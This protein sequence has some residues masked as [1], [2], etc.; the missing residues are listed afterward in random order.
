MEIVDEIKNLTQ[1]FEPLFKKE[2]IET[3]EKQRSFY[4]I[5]DTTQDE[6]KQ[7]ILDYSYGGKRI[8]P[9][10]VSYFAGKD[11]SD[12]QV[13]NACMAFEFFHLSALIHDDIIDNADFRRNSPTIHSYAMKFSKLS[14]TIGRDLAILYGDLFLTKCF[15]FASNLE[16]R[17][18]ESFFEMAK[19]T[20]QGQY[21]D[22]IGSNEEYGTIPEE[23]I[24]GRHELKTA[25]YTFVSPAEIGTSLKET[26]ESE[27]YLKVLNNLMMQIGLL[28]QIRDDIKDCTDEKTGKDLFKDIRENQ[29]T[30]VTLHIKKNYPDKFEF[31]L[32]NKNTLSAE[33]LKDFF[34]DIDLES[35]YKVEVEKIKELIA[36]QANDFE[37][38]KEKSLKILSLLE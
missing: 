30:W 14:K 8:R 34:T 24:K 32:K 27:N 20:I 11:L 16:T 35:P 23:Y 17:T 29:T 6:L 26:K 31:L 25:W 15:E 9:F 33:D 21:I 28:Y 10:I 22:T 7:V 37:E 13:F 36:S 19:R 1:E 3:L 4:N 2:I 12:K 38:L 5:A 18:K